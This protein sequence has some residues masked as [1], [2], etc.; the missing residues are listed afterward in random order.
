MTSND[1]YKFRNL[2]TPHNSCYNTL[3]RCTS[4]Y[5]YNE[6]CYSV[7]RMFKRVICTKATAY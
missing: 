6:Y 1:K 2:K 3:P 5:S 4:V 7:L